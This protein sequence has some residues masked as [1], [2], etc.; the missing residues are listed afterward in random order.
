MDF[1]KKNGFLQKPTK[2]KCK[3]NVNLV[4][5]GERNAAKTEGS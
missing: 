2:N 3:I 1:T 5:N 4:M